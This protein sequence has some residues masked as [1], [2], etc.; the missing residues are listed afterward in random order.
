M[1]TK[2]D[3]NSIFVQDSSSSPGDAAT[4]YAFAPGM[5]DL[6]ELDE[7]I[8]RYLERNGRAT[9]YEVGEAVALSASAALAGFWLW[10]RPA[11]F[12]GIAHKSTIGFSASA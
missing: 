4:K 12:A 8:L 5:T 11:P 10:N 1:G 7:A 9:N 3:K 6:D 2:R